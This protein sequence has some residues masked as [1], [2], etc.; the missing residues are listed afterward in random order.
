MVRSGSGAD[1]Y[2]VRRA[3]AQGLPKGSGNG[4]WSTGTGALGRWSN[5]AAPWPRSGSSCE[6]TPRHDSYARN[7]SCPYTESLITAMYRCVGWSLSGKAGREGWSDDAV[8][9]ESAQNIEGRSGVVVLGLAF[10]TT[11]LFHIST[12]Q[13]HRFSRIRRR[14]W[15]RGLTEGA[16]SGSETEP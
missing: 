2:I 15:A 14:L 11:M 12:F 9:R 3:G 1:G 10:N 6:D 4:S 16:D 13:F 7:P 8:M 5:S